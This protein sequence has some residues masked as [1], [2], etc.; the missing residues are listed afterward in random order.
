MGINGLLKDLLEKEKFSG[1]WDDD[2]DN[3]INIFN[4]L[5]TM[6]K[7]T[8]EEKLISIPIILWGESINYYS[9]HLEYFEDFEAAMRIFRK[10]YRSE[11]L[12]ARIP[13]KW[14]PMTL[15][16]AMVYDPN[17]SEI[18]IVRKF[19]SKF[20]SLR[21]KLDTSYHTNQILRYSLLTVVD[22]PAIKSTL[23]DRLPRTSQKA[24]NRIVNK[25]SDKP[26]SA[27]GISSFRRKIMR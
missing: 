21:N 5:S 11:D 6:C 7:L 19:S 17:N 1:S 3:C 9:T 2:I 22:I 4:T 16:E 13:S 18:S 14:K 15:S 27:R 26:I 23:R 8:P 24:I 25:F 12:N 20:M 10:S